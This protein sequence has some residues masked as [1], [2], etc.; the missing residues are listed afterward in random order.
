MR[1]SDGDHERDRDKD[2]YH[3]DDHDGHG[4]YDRTMRGGGVVMLTE[5][6]FVHPVSPGG[7]VKFLPAV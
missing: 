3:G 7:S 4:K 6:E 5:V 2:C 1:Y